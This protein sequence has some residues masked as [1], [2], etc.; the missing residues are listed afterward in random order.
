MTRYDVCDS[1]LLLLLHMYNIYVYHFR[2]VTRR[3]G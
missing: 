1:A 3:N 2:V